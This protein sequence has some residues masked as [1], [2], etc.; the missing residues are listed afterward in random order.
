MGKGAGNGGSS[1]L[2]QA[3]HFWP[4]NEGSGSTFV[5]HAGGTNLTTSG[6]IW[7]A[8]PAGMGAAPL[9]AG[10]NGSAGFAQA[11]VVDP[12]L[13]FNGLT[14]FTISVWVYPTG[15][16]SFSV[17]GNLTAPTSYEGWE[18]TSGG[19]TGTGILLV[20]NI[21]T[22]QMTALNGIPIVGSVP[23]LLTI[24]YNGSLSLAGVKMYINGAPTPV[25]DSSGTLSAAFTSAIPFLVGKR[26]DGTNF[27]T[28][29]MAYMRTWALAATP[30]QV[31]GIF[32]LGAQ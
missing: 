23:T 11:S 8:A 5:D 4:M 21:T 2:S 9:I 6:I 20:N 24:T 27:F 14:P 25:T 18:L 22:N 12:T 13:N 31:A 10:F 15:S 16:A 19:A 29:V 17:C 1:F 32:A 28:G 26:A 3:Q 7:T 30:T